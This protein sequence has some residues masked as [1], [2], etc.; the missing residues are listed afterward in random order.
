M[1]FVS[2]LQRFT[3]CSLNNNKLSGKLASS[4][5][6]PILFDDSLKITSVLYFAVD[7]NSLSYELNSFTFKLLY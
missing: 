7:F 4:L 1:L 6:L 5:E 3:T 2:A